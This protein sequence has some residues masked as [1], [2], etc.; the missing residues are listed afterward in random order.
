REFN[1]L[2][3]LAR[4]LG[5]AGEG[6]MLE[7]AESPAPTTSSVSLL[8]GRLVGS[9]LRKAV[10]LATLALALT[11]GVLGWRWLDGR[12]APANSIAVLPFVNVE[13]DP[14]M[15]YLPDGITESLIGS[16][17]QLPDLSVM[18]RDT[19]FT[20]K[21]REVDPRRVGDDLKVRAVVTG[22]VRRQGERLFIR[23]EL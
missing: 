8:F 6:A 22:R 23:A 21:G 17:S 16:L 7:T 4:R 10:A 13:N 5:F 14:Q 1:S 11:G 3:R 19:V 20:Y 12:G 18:A 15:E 9:P 2:A